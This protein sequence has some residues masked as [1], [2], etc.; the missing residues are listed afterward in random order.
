MNC[1]LWLIVEFFSHLK[2]IRRYEIVK[3]K[4]LGGVFMIMFKQKNFNASSEASEV[5]VDTVKRGVPIG[6]TGLFGMG[7]WN[8][9][10]GPPF[11]FQ[12]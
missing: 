7:F 10:K 8:G 4:M 11:N 6:S 12:P 3:Q 9:Q 2:L 1:I 5:Y